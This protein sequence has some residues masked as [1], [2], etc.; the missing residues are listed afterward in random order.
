[1]INIQV[2]VYLN[3]ALAEWHEIYS[4]LMKHVLL[5]LLSLFM[6]SALYESEIGRAH[7]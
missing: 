7:V 3:Y 1:M 5:L 2:H 4:K 6:L